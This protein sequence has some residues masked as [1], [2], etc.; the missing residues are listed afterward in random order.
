M[1]KLSI[2]VLLTMLVGTSCKITDT[3]PEDKENLIKER[4]SSL[5]AINNWQLWSKA[6][7]N[8][9]K[10]SG[11]VS[12]QW[13][14]EGD[15]YSIEIVAPMG[16]GRW[17]ITGNSDTVI[18]ENSHGEKYIGENPQQLFKKNS[19]LDVPIN[20]LFYW[21]KGIPAPQEL[22][23]A[24]YDGDGRLQVLHQSGWNI[25]Y[26]RYAS[27]DGYYMPIKVFA[28]SEQKKFEFRL[29]IKRWS[30]DG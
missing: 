7:V 14:Q 1:K 25:E 27:V 10:E 6:G 9:A 17:Q 28:K 19:G 15:N 13:T 18:L 2:L 12:L 11:T 29:S 22:E 16:K 24:D 26:R 5:E 21:I 8:T 4:Q 23:R 30:I 20:N 3:K